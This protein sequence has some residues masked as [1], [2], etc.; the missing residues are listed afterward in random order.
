MAKIIDITKKNSHHTEKFSPA[1][2]IVALAGTYEAEV[3]ILHYY[4]ETVEELLPQMAELIGINVSDFILETG[5]LIGLD[6]GMKQ[7]ELSPLVYH[8]AKGDVEYSVL[9]LYQ[10]R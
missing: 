3:D 5:S 10:G 9:F 2:E 8:A 4:A 1:A 7:G 6:M